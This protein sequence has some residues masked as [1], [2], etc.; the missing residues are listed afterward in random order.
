MNEIVGHFDFTIP[1]NLPCNSL[2]PQAYKVSRIHADI[3]CIL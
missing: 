3:V 2:H 1:D